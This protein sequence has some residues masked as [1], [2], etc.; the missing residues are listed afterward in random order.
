MTI[1]RP[2][3]TPDYIFSHNPIVFTFRKNAKDIGKALIQR[4]HLP[5]VN[6]VGR[7]MIDYPVRELVSDDICR[8]C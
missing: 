7:N 4:S 2:M 5:G 3:A 6:K 8:A 1:F